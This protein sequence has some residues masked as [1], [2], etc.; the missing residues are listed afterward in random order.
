MSAVKLTIDG[1]AVEVAP[2]TTI[3]GA[4]RSLGVSIPTLCYVEG[5]EHS[6]SCFLCAVKLEGRPNLWPSCA[7]PVAEGMKVITASD[8]VRAARKTSL[9]L[10]L[11]DHAGDCI[12]PCRTGCPAQLDIPGFIAGIAGGDQQKAAGMVTDDLTLPA[13]LGRVCP[14]L[15]EQR[16]R[17]CDVT[18]ALSIRNLHRFAAD[19]GR[20]ASASPKPNG[21]VSAKGAGETPASPSKRVAIVGAGPAGLAAAHHLLRRGHGVVL[22]DAHPQGGRDAALRHPGVSVAARRAGCRNRHGLAARGRVSPGQ[23]PG[24]GFHARGTAAGLRRRLPGHRCPGLARPG[25]SRR[26]IGHACA[27]VPG[28]AC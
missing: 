10:L 11:S 27:G 14:R 3:L 28:E 5:F 13:S 8:E 15:C 23:T 6:A 17:Q 18:E 20:S 26:R 24:P 12:G 21:A 4:A 19:A 9:E 16:C 22:F 25:L 1:R 2:G 7:T